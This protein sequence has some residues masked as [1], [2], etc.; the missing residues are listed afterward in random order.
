MRSSRRDI[1]RRLASCVAGCVNASLGFMQYRGYS[2]VGANAVNGSLRAPLN[3]RGCDIA[4]FGS[5]LFR[6][7]TD[8]FQPRTPRLVHTT[9][10]RDLHRAT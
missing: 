9:D 4:A 6:L 1:L 7:P 5:T 2:N 10:H 8:L 3:C